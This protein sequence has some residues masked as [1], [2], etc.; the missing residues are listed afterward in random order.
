MK[1]ARARRETSFK[2]IGCVG[3]QSRTT[4]SQTNWFGHT[5]P[6]LPVKESLRIPTAPKLGI[7]LPANRR[8]EERPRVSNRRAKWERTHTCLGAECR[9]GLEGRHHAV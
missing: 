8:L 1:T 4:V 7:G 3:K 9:V 2:T 6:I 5:Q